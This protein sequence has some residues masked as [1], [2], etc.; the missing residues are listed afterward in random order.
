MSSEHTSVLLHEVID[1]LNIQPDGQYVDATLGLGGHAL[2]ILKR[3]GPQ[4]KVLGIDRDMSSL[5]KAKKNLYVYSRQ[6]E[7]AHANF[8]QLKQVL[9]D[10]NM[11]KIDG[12][13]FDLGVSSV[14]LDDPERGFSIRQDGPL[15][16]RMDQSATQSAA[17][18]VNQLTQPEL[19]KILRE[20][21]DERYAQRVA[22][23]IITERAKSPIRTT[24]ELART[25]L[26]A[27]PKG[28]KWQKIHPATRTFQAIRIAVNQELEIL[29]KTFHSAVEAL[30]PGGRICV[31]AFHSLE[32]RIV[33]L[34]FKEMKKENKIEI[35]T[36][37]P[38]K[39]GEEEIASNPRA[40]SGLLRVAERM[41]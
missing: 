3:L 2:A 35:L 40:R 25:V 6:C 34:T 33:K 4:G 12:I 31:I 19:A 9:A 10:H 36:K 21:G 14:Q 23:A 16:M 8:S 15:D 29:A 39:P 26:K 18:L 22:S 20:W 27:M 5:T 28:R 41:A 38:L 11:Q 17:D 24:Q 13:V 30:K 37:K 7:F 1:F 32:D